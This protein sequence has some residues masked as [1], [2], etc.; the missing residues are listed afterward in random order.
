MANNYTQFSDGIHHLTKEE[1]AWIRSVLIDPTVDPDGPDAKNPDLIWNQDNED[2]GFDWKI[3]SDEINGR[4]LCLYTNSGEGD[5]EQVILL[6][7][8]FLKKFRP[9]EYFTV[10]WACT[11]SRPRVGEF[12]GGAAIVTAKGTKYMNTD[13]WLA[14]ELTKID[15]RK[16]GK[17]TK[18]ARK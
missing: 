17:R 12:G 1:E 8:R 7:Q 4:Y 9:K 13:T 11:C 18:K 5:V 2:L 3:V 14:D 6:A 10:E 15:R 16:R